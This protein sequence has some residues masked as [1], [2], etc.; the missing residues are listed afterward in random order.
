MNN[1]EEGTL[2]ASRLKVTSFPLRA[3]SF[4]LFRYGMKEFIFHQALCSNGH[5]ASSDG[6]CYSANL[7]DPAGGAKSQYAAIWHMT[8]RACQKFPLQPVSFSRWDN[9]PLPTG[10]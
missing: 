7:K 3:L 5:F 2:L 4:V 9:Q 8:Q 6:I 10:R 1:V